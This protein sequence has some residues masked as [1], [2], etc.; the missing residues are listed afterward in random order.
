[1]KQ[2]FCIIAA[3]LVI[4]FPVEQAEG[5]T[6]YGGNGLFRV[7]SA[8]NVYSGALW[9]TIN[10][11]YAQKAHSTGSFTFRDGTGAISLL[12]G[13]SRYLEIGINQTIYQDQV[14]STAGPSLGPLRIS[15]KGNVP[16]SQPPTI[17]FGAQIFVSIPVGA[18]S[19]VHW[20]SY[21]SPSS[22][23]GGMI[24]MSL[25]SNPLDL[26]RSKRLHFNAGLIYHNDKNK[27]ATSEIVEPGE[28]VFSI[29][30]VNAKN[31]LQTIFGVGLQAPLRDNIHFF[32][33]LTA[34]YFMDLN[35]NTAIA[36]E[37]SDISTYVRITPGIRYQF[38]RF[39]VV[40]GIEIRPLSPGNYIA[41]DNS[42]IYPPWRAILNLQYRLF[43][44]DPPSYLH[45][46]SMR[47]LG[48]SN[49]L[50]EQQ[51]DDMDPE[52][53]IEEIRQDRIKSQREL[54]EMKES[55]EEDPGASR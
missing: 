54:E 4:G 55:M 24:I 45:G 1:M 41:F 35:P 39:N 5:I 49:Y 44:G 12:Y 13:V 16:T 37:G 6:S 14:F 52:E 11:D 29:S 17:N 30:S 32:T 33:E 27:Y 43:E 36:R 51:A 38:S 23:V 42:R 50:Y 26:N 34:E 22:S 19:D 3:I 40:S 2:I 10:M 31:S 47:L 21:I 46:R 8:N 28:G 25:D 9:G 20:E 18:A 53:E 48:R 7:Q 15:L